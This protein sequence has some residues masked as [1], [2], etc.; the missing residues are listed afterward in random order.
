MKQSI[1]S[2]CTILGLVAAL[3]TPSLFATDSVE[4]V[5]DT[6]HEAEKSTE[7][8]PILQKALKQLE[9]YNPHTGVGHFRANNAASHEHKVAAKHRIEQAIEVATA[10]QSANEKITAAISEI[11]LTGQFKH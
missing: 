10:G 6:L 9:H 5:I 1:R 4:E 3:A 2:L 8:V 7:P 11:R